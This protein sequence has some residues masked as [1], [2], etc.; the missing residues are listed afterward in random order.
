MRRKETIISTLYMQLL[1]ESMSESVY[2]LESKI[3]VLSMTH[4]I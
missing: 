2:K 4:K 3:T 1:E